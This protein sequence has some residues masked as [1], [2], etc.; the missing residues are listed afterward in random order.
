MGTVFSSRL[1]KHNRASRDVDK[2]YVYSLK[3]HVAT[4]NVSHVHT[5]PCCV[6]QQ[7][8]CGVLGSVRFQVTQIDLIDPLPQNQT[9]HLNKLSKEINNF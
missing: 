3:V 1:W 9:L 2:Q 5:I 8:H 7:P 4:R 6:S